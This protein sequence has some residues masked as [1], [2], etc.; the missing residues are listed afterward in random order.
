[1]LPKLP[2]VTT[3]LQIFNLMKQRAFLMQSARHGMQ[4]SIRSSVVNAA[5]AANQAA[6]D[7]SNAYNYYTSSGKRSVAGGSVLAAVSMAVV[8]LAL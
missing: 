5:Q 1:M 7:A 2:L 3:L 8:M 6:R 4:V